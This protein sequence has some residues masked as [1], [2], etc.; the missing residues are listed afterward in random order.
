M[1][2][3]SLDMIK[4]FNKV[5]GEDTSDWARNTS[6]ELVDTR[7]PENSGLKVYK[8]LFRNLET[9]VIKLVLS[10]VI[11]KRRRSISRRNAI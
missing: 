2:S 10:L 9:K 1:G 5:T 6:Q 3:G 8:R 4:S 11:P 7:V